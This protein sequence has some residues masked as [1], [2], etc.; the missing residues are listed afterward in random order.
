[1]NEAPTLTAKRKLKVVAPLETPVGP[2]WFPEHHRMLAIRIE[3]P[4]TGPPEPLDYPAFPRGGVVIVQV[5]KMYVVISYRP[6][7][8]RYKLT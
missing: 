7:C 3:V 1:M 2:Q 6:V 4:I 5:H 8:S